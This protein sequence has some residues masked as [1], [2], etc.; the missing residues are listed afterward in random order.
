MCRIHRIGQKSDTVRIVYIIANNTVDTTI[1]YVQ[2]VCIC[3][4]VC[5]YINMHIH[6]FFCYVVYKHFY[7]FYCV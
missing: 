7:I 5:M 1:W 2:N 4:C 3:V 6:I